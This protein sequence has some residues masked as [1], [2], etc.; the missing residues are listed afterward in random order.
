VNF[1]WDENKRLKTIEDRGLDFIR[2]RRFFDGRPAIHQPSPRNDE[3]RWK[4]TIKMDDALYTV[5]W[6]WRGEVRHIISMRRAH[7]QEIKKYRE[8]HGG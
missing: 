8:L 5:V 6:L 3:D 2:A 1:S 7:G 4:S